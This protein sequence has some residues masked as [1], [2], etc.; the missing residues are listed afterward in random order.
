MD[1]G[2][3]PELAMHFIAATGHILQTF[4]HEA[5]EIGVNVY[6]ALHEPEA[7]ARGDR[8]FQIIKST[9][10]TVGVSLALAEWGVLG[11]IGFAI[12]LTEGL[13]RL[14]ECGHNWRIHHPQPNH[15]SGM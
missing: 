1:L 11:V 6:T 2:Q 15:P 14:N 4:P 13:I 12:P 9:G 3:I 7:M 8:W 5:S 10:S